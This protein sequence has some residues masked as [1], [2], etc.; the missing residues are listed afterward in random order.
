MAQRWCVPVCLHVLCGWNLTQST[1]RSKSTRKLC[2]VICMKI[3]LIWGIQTAVFEVLRRHLTG[4]TK[5][6]LGT[7]IT[8]AG[9]RSEMGEKERVS[10]LTKRRVGSQSAASRGCA[11]LSIL[12]THRLFFLLPYSV[13]STSL[14]CLWSYLGNKLANINLHLSATSTYSHLL[15]SIPVPLQASARSTPYVCPKTHLH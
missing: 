3:W 11:M 12:V 9:L 4:R 5:E 2:S 7:S 1:T 13:L 6:N 10:R 15:F 8:T 14:L